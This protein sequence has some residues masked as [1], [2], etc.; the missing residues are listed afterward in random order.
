MTRQ[1]NKKIYSRVLLVGVIV[2]LG[3]TVGAL[4]FV[5]QAFLHSS[6]SGHGVESVGIIPETNDPYEL[7]EYYFNQQEGKGSYDLTKARHYYTEA[8]RKDPMGY[9]RAWYQ[10]G[11][12]DFIEGK[13]SS[14][15][16]K[17]EKQI[18][19]F[20]DEVPNVYYMLG[21][22]YG[23]L[24]RETGE[25]V[26]WQKAEAF[27]Q[28]F[29]GFTQASPWPR[30]DLAWVYFS[31]GKYAEMLPVL[32]EGLVYEPNHAW[33]L[34]TYGLALLNIDERERA[35]EQFLKARDAADALTVEDWGR[36]YTGNDPKSWEGGL[37][38]FRAVI[39]YNIEMS[40]SR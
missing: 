29:I 19:Y 37:A 13:F 3:S 39:E 23:Y 10:L 7:G 38:E 16:Y 18:E 11:R 22:T 40:E 14:A 21:L 33:L 28:R 34:N 15:I 36:A 20:G 31:Q 6:L 25:E 24:A 8:L 9:P 17:F 35:H 27:F 30:V 32:E 5:G 2:V 4:L 12:I 1:S 26:D